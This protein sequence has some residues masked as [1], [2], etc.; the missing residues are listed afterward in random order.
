MHPRIAPSDQLLATA[1]EQ[2]GVL[3]AEQVKLLDFSLRSTERMVNQRNWS[4]LATGV[5]YVGAGRPAWLG[6][7]WAG[8]LLGGADAR[9]GFEAAGHLW[10]LV[11][12][13]PRTITVL[14]PR[15]RQVTKRD[16]WVFRSEVA[17]MRSECSPGS[18]PRTTIEDTVVDLCDQAE[19]RDL[20][21]LLSTAVQGRR[22][23]A[24]RIRECVEARP[25][26]RHRR[27]LLRML[28]DVAEG[29]E[30]PL[31]VRYLRDVERAHGLPRARRQTRSS[32]GD[33]I[34]DM[35][36]AEFAIIVELDGRIH[37]AGRFRDMR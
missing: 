23:T 13:P 17:G 4:R 19:P 10:S 30:S 8:V 24:R 26:V 37:I 20:V 35:L 31:E 11:E 18:P 25:K 12:Q 5:Y 34:R 2:G 6:L 3:S 16:L 28:A 9:L 32:R 1:L 29:A 21:G 36:Y 27:L 14:V 7:A 33:E 15:G 22:T